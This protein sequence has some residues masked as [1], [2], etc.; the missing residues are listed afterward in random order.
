ML[1]RESYT[2][3]QA[4]FTAF[5]CHLAR[6][7]SS[8]DLENVEAES[9]IVR[10]AELS[11]PRARESREHLR[12][13]SEPPHFLFFFMPTRRTAVVSELPTIRSEPRA[14]LFR[15]ARPIFVCK[16]RWASPPEPQDAV[17]LWLWTK[18]YIMPKNNNCL[19]L[20]GL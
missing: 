16:S 9:R 1:C 13:G 11:G 19:K 14:S 3:F 5:Y 15:T 2:E 12:E 18:K 7:Y 4:I 6:P 20:L 10:T 17:L 8:L